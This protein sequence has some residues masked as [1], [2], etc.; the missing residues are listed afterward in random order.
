M[1]TDLQLNCMQ[2]FYCFLK[3]VKG[4]KLYLD[5][6]LPSHLDSALNLDWR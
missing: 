3:I 6:I 4:A 2:Q 1:T 5:K